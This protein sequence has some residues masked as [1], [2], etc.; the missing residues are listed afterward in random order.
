MI[1]S[2]TGYGRGRAAEGEIAVTAEVRSVNGRQQ[3]IRFRL[4]P[5]LYPIEP[6]LRRRAQQHAGRGRIDIAVNWER[7]APPV[8]RYAI[9]RAAA[10]ALFEGWRGLS[11]ELGLWD[12][13]RIEVLLRLPG[14]IE[15]QPPEALD[16]DVVERVALEAVGR[17]LEENRRAREEEGRRLVA[18]IVPRVAAIRAGTVAIREAAERIP[19]RVANA[20]RERVAPLLGEIPLDEGRLAQEAAL[21][22]QRAD[23]TEELVRLDAHLGRLEALLEGGTEGIGRPVEFLVQEIRREISTVAAKSADPEIDARALEIKSEL[24][25]IREQVANLE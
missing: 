11:E 19:A 21:A 24:E 18:D 10:R 20:I 7:G 3:E 15:A 2:M 25:K 22:A 23:V 4:P 5:E 14:V 17:A 13:P 1:R 12:E 8:P 16:L 9:N 6:A